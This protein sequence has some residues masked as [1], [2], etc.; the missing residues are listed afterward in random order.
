MASTIV[1]PTRPDVGAYSD[2][3]NTAM[4][5]EKGN[6]DGRVA[7][8][9]CDGFAAAVVDIEALQA[10]TSVVGVNGVSMPAG[11]ALAV[12][13]VLRATSATAAAYGDVMYTVLA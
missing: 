6:Y 10:G 8:A 3:V 9:I 4:V 13:S 12:G 5:T 1:V 11:G 7:D 2:A